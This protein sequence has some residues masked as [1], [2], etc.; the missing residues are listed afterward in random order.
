[1]KSKIIIFIWEWWTEIDFFD[2][3]IRRLYNESID[4]NLKHD[5]IIKIWKNFIIF[6]HPVT[7]NS[8]HIWWDNS[9]KSG[10]TYTLIRLKLESLKHLIDF[11]Q[12][13]KEYIYFYLTDN[14]KVNSESKLDWVDEI[15]KEK[16]NWFYWDI[17]LNFAKKEIETWFLLWLWNEFK[18]IYENIDEKELKKFLNKKKYEEIDNTKE[19]L[20]KV[21]KN[22][23]IWKSS[24]TIWR[25]FWKY[26]NIE[27][28]E[29]KSVSFSNFIK[30][31][32][33][34]LW[35]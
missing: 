30:N 12:N 6:A 23:K 5:K 20:Y 1:M 18:K 32:K 7:W 3:I 15:I 25:L 14:D 10:K 33:D 34:I 21:L 17:V 8:K 35:D 9:L 11:S 4:E 24:K 27:E 26:L 19:I 13:K 16:C 28:A 22:T 2:A 31:I 29:N